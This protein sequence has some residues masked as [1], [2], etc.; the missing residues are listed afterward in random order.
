MSRDR[1][2]DAPRVETSVEAIRR[3]SHCTVWDGRHLPCDISQTPVPLPSSS[4]L[5]SVFQ[6]KPRSKHISPFLCPL[7]PGSCK[8][9][10]T[11]KLVTN[12]MGPAC[13]GSWSLTLGRKIRARVPETMTA[14][15]GDS[16]KGS[17]TGA[18]SDAAERR[19]RRNRSRASHARRAW[20]ADGSSR[21]G[22]RGWT[23]QQ[24]A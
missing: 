8:V 3:D 19:R 12:A 10:S 20:A 21:S 17:I 18:R 13:S 2:C 1:A 11:R 14:G 15:G 24:H 22:R 6:L 16:A 4:V 9:C 5:V 23:D 7:L